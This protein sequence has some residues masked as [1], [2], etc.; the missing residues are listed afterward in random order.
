[1]NDFDPA[2]VVELDR[3]APPSATPLDWS[4][5]LARAGRRRTSMG[6]PVVVAVFAAVAVLATPALGIRSRVGDLLGLHGG[7]RPG[8]VAALT[9][10][11]GSGS[12]SLVAAP[13]RPFTP[14]GSQRTVG[15]SRSL[16]VT[17]RFSGLSGPATT[18]LLRVTPPRGSA[19]SGYVVRLCGPCRSGATIQIQRRGLFLA[20]LAGRGTA[21]IATAAHP[22]GELQ[23]RLLPTRTMPRTPG[24]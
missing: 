19:G 21:V 6:V 23:G 11:A 5:V 12:G 14:V 10:V 22:T 16:A 20:L 13:V 15:F 1:V 7:P 17:I 2:L 4:D 8:F 18:G 9:P 24:G 3:L